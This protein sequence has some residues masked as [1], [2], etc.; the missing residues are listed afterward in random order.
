MNIN[1]YA[2]FFI[3]K[4]LEPDKIASKIATILI[5]FNKSSIII[6]Y[7]IYEKLKEL[8][9][10]TQNINLPEDAKVLK[11]KSQ[12]ITAI[13]YLSIIDS[14]YLCIDKFISLNNKIFCYENPNSCDYILFRI[15]EQNN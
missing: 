1:A 4:N 13:F 8:A 10:A 11:I 12:Q 2:K 6:D 14:N 9:I 5:S 3:D 15:A 7:K